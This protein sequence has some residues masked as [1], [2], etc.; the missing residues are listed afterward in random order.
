MSKEKR[1]KKTLTES[2]EGLTDPRNPDDILHK[3]IDI[4]AFRIAERNTFS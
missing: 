2:F 4:V 3:L 1:E